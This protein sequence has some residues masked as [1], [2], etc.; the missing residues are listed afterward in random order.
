M[1][2]TGRLNIV[3]ISHLPKLIFLLNTIQNEFFRRLYYE[4]WQTNFRIL[5]EKDQEYL[6]G[7][8]LLYIKLKMKL[9]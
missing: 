2:M 4:N 5:M 8:V 7:L 6:L 3:K 1:L 9:Q